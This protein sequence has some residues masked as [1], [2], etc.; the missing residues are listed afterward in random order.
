MNAVHSAVNLSVVKS[1]NLSQHLIELKV[2]C[3]LLN[4]KCVISEHTNVAYMFGTGPADSCDEP[5]G[6]VW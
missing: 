6:Y 3:K 2:L 5:M 1:V 4:C